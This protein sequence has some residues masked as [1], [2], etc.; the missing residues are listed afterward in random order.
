VAPQDA[1][2]TAVPAKIVGA[3]GSVKT[4]EAAFEPAQPA[5]VTEKALYVPAFKPVKEKAFPETV[6]F[7]GL[8]VAPV[9]PGVKVNEYVPLGKL[10][11]VKAILPVPPQVVGLVT[12][13]PVMVGAAGSDTVLDVETEPIQPLLITVKAL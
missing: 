5:F 9:P 1:G 4:F 8:V 7:F 12:D 10:V 13:P 6:T 11:V 3:A 2:F